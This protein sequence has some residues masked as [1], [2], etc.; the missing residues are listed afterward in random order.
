MDITYAAATLTA[1]AAEGNDDNAVEAEE[2]ALDERNIGE[3]GE[4][5]KT[6]EAT[7]QNQ[8]KRLREDKGSSRNSK[9][10]VRKA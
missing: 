6:G 9:G 8:A 7:P 1:L 2:E 4:E 3:E 10:H 5:A